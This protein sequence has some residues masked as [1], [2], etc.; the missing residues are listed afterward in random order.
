VS[1]NVYHIWAEVLLSLEDWRA[2]RTPLLLSSHHF[3]LGGFRLKRVGVIVRQEL[4]WFDVS[5][6]DESCFVLSCIAHVYCYDFITGSGQHPN[7]VLVT[8]HSLYVLVKTLNQRA[9][10]IL[11]LY[12]L[13]HP[14]VSISGI[15]YESDG[16]SWA[17]VGRLGKDY[18]FGMKAV[19]MIFREQ[20]SHHCDDR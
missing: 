7:T 17:S 6:I 4:F 2:R 19:M 18:S 8:K 15:G 5:S 11:I 12:W 3:W 9:Y 16:A 20:A 13:F 14:L 10:G 1:D